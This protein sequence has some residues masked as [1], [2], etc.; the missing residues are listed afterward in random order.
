MTATKQSSGWPPDCGC[1]DLHFRSPHGT[2]RHPGHV[3]SVAASMLTVAK[4]STVMALTRAAS[5]GWYGRMCT[6]SA[7]GASAA[8]APFAPSRPLNLAPPLRSPRRRQARIGAV[9]GDCQLLETTTLMGGGV[10]GDAT[11]SPGHHG[12]T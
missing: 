4:P 1:I 5:E 8:G 9:S 11:P 12:R 10:R 7:V 6:A 2:G 3:W